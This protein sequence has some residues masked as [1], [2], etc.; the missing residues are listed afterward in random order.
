MLFLHFLLLRSALQSLYLYYS[1]PVVGKGVESYVC[2]VYYPF[3]SLY[4]VMFDTRGKAIRPSP[5]ATCYFPL[6]C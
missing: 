2:K 6:T 3:F 4:Q 1:S 5:S